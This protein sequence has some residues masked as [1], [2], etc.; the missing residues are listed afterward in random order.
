MVRKDFNSIFDTLCDYYN[1]KEMKENESIRELY[2]DQLKYYDPQEWLDI[3]KTLLAKHKYMPKIQE[4]ITAVADI[5]RENK[6]VIDIN[7][8]VCECDLCNGTGYR[9]IT[10]PSPKGNT[11]TFVVACD[12]ANG[13]SKVYDGRTIKD[14]KHR[15]NYICPRYSSMFPE[16]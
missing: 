15:S 7:K 8:P 4:I 12:C 1:Q 6:E 13:D 3:Q 14:K 2:F 16:G 9:F 10:E 5:K 11:Y